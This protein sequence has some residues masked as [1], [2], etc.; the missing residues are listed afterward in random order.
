MQPWKCKYAKIHTQNQQLSV[1]VNQ[2]F[3]FIYEKFMDDK[4]N[5]GS[6]E[7]CGS[8]KNHGVYDDKWLH[9]IFLY[10][11]SKKITLLPLQL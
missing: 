7:K 5:A 10:H 6:H 4:A 9:F 11:I 1:M 8:R 2:H 3:C